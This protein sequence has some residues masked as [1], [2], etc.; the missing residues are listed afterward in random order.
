MLNDNTQ[1]NI[2][3]K[4]FRL[5]T[6]F[7][8]MTNTKYTTQTGHKLMDDQVTDWSSTKTVTGTFSKL[9]HNTADSYQLYELWL[10]FDFYNYTVLNAL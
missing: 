4:D 2:N 9:R 1:H 10:L 6:G 7:H 3:A 8:S 5:L